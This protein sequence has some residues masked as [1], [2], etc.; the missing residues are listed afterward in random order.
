MSALWTSFLVKLLL[1]VGEGIFGW[2]RGKHDEAVKKTVDS[3]Q[4]TIDSV[5]V[6]VKTE[7]D[8]KKDQ[9]NVKPADVQK[10]DGGVDVSTWNSGK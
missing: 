9:A 1:K 6:A 3:Q 10:P 5:N 2:L 4:Q 7:D 8:I